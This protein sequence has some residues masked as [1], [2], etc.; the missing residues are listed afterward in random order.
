MDFLS[1]QLHALLDPEMLYAFGERFFSHQLT[2]MTM[3]FTMAAFIHSIR[4]KKEIKLA[5]TSLTDS[6]TAVGVTIGNEVN[7][8]KREV[9]NLNTRVAEVEKFVGIK[10]SNNAGS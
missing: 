5:F 6:I 2:Q 9:S 8:V 3:A 7:G 10:T 1:A 4:V